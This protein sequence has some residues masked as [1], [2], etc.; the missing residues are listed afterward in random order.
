MGATVTELRLNLASGS[1]ARV[2][3]GWRNLDIVE[4]WPNSPRPRD[5]HWDARTDKIP[6]HDA[7]VDEIFAGYLLTH[8]SYRHHAPLVR[9]MFR[10]LKPGALVTIDEVDMRQAVQRWLAN[11]FDQD[12]RNICWGECGIVH[13][14]DL[15]EF[16][17]HRSGLTWAV[18][19]K[20][21]TD[22][23]FRGVERITRHAPEV[24][25]AMTCRAMK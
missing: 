3:N 23:G 20:L 4:Q 8:V 25:Y 1:D 2:G 17:A 5:E 16:D 24:W 10:V 22:A 11:P 15:E 7:S 13:G 19:C 9:E 21:L 6:Y 18:L 14:Q 12:A